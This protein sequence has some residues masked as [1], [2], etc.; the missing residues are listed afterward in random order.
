[1][2]AKPEKVEELVLSGVGLVHS[3]ARSMSRGGVPAC[4]ELAELV[5]PGMLGLVEA[6]QR[7]DPAKNMQFSSFALSRIRGAILDHLRSTNVRSRGT[8]KVVKQ[9]KLTI[10]KLGQTTGSPPTREEVLSSIGLSPD[11]ANRPEY[12]QPAWRV[13]LDDYVVASGVQAGEVRPKRTPPELVVHGKAGEDELQ[14][15][16]REKAAREVLS[17]LEPRE[18]RV[19]ELYFFEGLTLQEIGERI[20]CCESRVSQLYSRAIGRMRGH[21]RK[22]FSDPAR[23]L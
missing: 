23:Q 18:R 22:R 11:L 9:I 21:L 17:Q 16:E 10:Q 5:G 13:S 4:V 12:W 15:Q 20:G 1:M 2:A 7:Y 3:V 8:M 14:A 19:V 6:A